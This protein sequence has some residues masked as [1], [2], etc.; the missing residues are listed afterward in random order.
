MGIRCNFS[1]G[2]T[3]TFCLYFAVCWRCNTN[4]RLQSA[5]PF[6]TMLYPF[7][8][9]CWRCN[10]NGR[11]QSALHKKKSLHF[12]AVVT[13]IRFVGSNSQVYCNKLQN[14]LSANFKQGTFLQRS[15]L[16]WS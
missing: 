7:W 15:K 6:L 2:E 8:R 4:G 12:T 10:T 1:R 11:L 13:K 9:F 5:L 14:R 3:S 16:P